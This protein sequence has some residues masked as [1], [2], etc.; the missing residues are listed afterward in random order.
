MNRRGK[1]SSWNNDA[2]WKG[3]DGSRG[4]G[5]CGGGRVVWCGVVVGGINGHPEAWGYND[6]WWNSHGDFHDQ[7]LGGGEKMTICKSHFSH[8]IFTQM[9]R[10]QWLLK[11]VIFSPPPPTNQPSKM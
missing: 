8:D 4:E 9:A 11:M 1:S 5:G 6:F 10:L 2:S 7:G 3:S